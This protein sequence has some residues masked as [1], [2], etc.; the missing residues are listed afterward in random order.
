MRADFL[1]EFVPDGGLIS[2]FNNV[3]VIGDSLSSGEHES[4]NCGVKGFHD[5]YWYSWGQ[6]ISRKAGCNVKNYSVGGLTA[7]QFNDYFAW[8]YHVFD[9]ENLCQAY[10]VALGVNDI[11]GVVGGNM[12]FGSLDDVDFSDYN[13]NKDSFISQYVKIIQRIVEAQPKAKI[14][15]VVPPEEEGRD[16]KRVKY[17]NK[18]AEILRELPKYFENL[19]LID[20]AKYADVHDKEFKEMYY[21]GGHLNAMGYRYTADLFMTYIDYIIKND[22]KKFKQVA[23]IGKDVHND[24]DVW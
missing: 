22:Y 2:I 3:A 8:F 16:E 15:A 20:M 12:E 23:F 13:K 10:F 17:Y 4:L 1:K 7:K 5:Y 21:L 14:F 24:E 9:K 11:S 6:Y 18:F 19:Y